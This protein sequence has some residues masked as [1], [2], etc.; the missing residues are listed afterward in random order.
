MSPD[1]DLPRFRMAR[2]VPLR[3]ARAAIERLSTLSRRFVGLERMLGIARPIT[4]LESLETYRASPD[5]P[6][7]DPV[8]TGTHAASTV[9]D[10]IGVGI[11]PATGLR[12]RLEVE[13]GMRI[14]FLDDLPASVAGLVMW[15]REL[16]PCIGINRNHSRGQRRWALAHELGHF[17]RN[18]SAGNLLPSAGWHSPTAD[19]VFAESFSKALLLPRASVSKQ[20]ADRCR[21][22]GGHFTVADILW[23]AHLY[24]VTFRRMTERLEALGFFPDGTYKKLTRDHY[25]P[26]E[27]AGVP[28][29]VLPDRRRP[30][31]FPVRFR[32]LAFEAFERQELNASQLSEYLEMDRFS[33]KNLYQR[34][35]YQLLGD[36]SEVELKLSD[37]VV[38]LH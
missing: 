2:E 17:L 36:G 28:S 8:L 25:F 15:S 31:A 23:L 29:K 33:A 37:E 13:G 1:D 3:E 18:R 6:G 30:D 12:E 32:I 27:D 20:F 16:G 34:W 11:G 38:T 22:N 21:A 5:R 26:D 14:F 10:I 24:D 7:L 35:R 4:P 19:D 9:R